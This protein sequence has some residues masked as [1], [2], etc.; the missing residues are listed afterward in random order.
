MKK[1]AKSARAAGLK[2]YEYPYAFLSAG[3]FDQL[4]KHE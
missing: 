3:I 4:K 1:I 2:V